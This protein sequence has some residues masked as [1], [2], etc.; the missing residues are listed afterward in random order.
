MGLSNKCL[1]LLNIICYG[2]NLFT[3]ILAPRK[4]PLTVKFCNYFYRWCAH[5]S[6]SPIALRRPEGAVKGLNVDTVKRFSDCDLVGFE[7]I[8][9]CTQIDCKRSS[10]L[11]FQAIDEIFWL[12]ALLTLAQLFIFIKNLYLKICINKIRAGA[13]HCFWETLKSDFWAIHKLY[14]QARGDSPNVYTRATII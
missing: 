9:S 4:R 12:P 3:N 8:F 14:R 13:Q 1:R 7:W 2:A 6:Q 5:R 10:D 11:I